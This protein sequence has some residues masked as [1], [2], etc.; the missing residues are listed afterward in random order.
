MTLIYFVVV[1]FRDIL[2]GRKTADPSSNSESFDVGDL[3]ASDEPFQVSEI[4]GGFAI[5]NDLLEPALITRIPTTP[6]NEIE[7]EKEP[8]TMREELEELL[9]VETVLGADVA[10]H[11]DGLS[12]SMVK[13]C[14]VIWIHSY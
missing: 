13:Q 4:E 10:A 8:E 5:G 3:A 1:T 9:L 2:T 6:E 7:R 11:R 14:E 12:D